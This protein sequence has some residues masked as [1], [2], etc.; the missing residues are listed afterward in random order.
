M[1]RFRNWCFT[2]NNYTDDEYSYLIG[3]EGH[4]QIKYMIIGKEIGEQEKTPHIQGFV[5]FHN[6]KLFSQVK[7]FFGERFHIEQCQGTPQQ[8]ISYC[9]KDDNF[10]EF[11]DPPHQGSR[12]D[13]SEVKE[14]FKSNIPINQIIENAKSYQ[15]ARHA[16]LLLKYQPQPKAQK[17]IIK[18]YY[19]EAGSGKTRKAV[20]DA[21]DDYYITMNTLKWWDGYFGQK[22]IIIDDFRKDFCTFHELLRILDRYPYKV[23]VKGS[24]IWLQPTTEVIIITSCYSPYQVYDTREDIGQLLRRI[25]EIVPFFIP[26]KSN[27]IVYKHK[28]DGLSQVS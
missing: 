8:N 1:S 28:Q 20:E 22:T 2:L 9:S 13:I 11:G 16:E 12:S 23:N 4:K 17:R 27:V 14:M 19:G 26:K 3:F 6:A 25:D 10:F 18:W 7:N 24:S 21:G 5:I 15:S